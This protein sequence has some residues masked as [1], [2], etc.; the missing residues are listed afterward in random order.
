MRSVLAVVGSK[1]FLGLLC[2]TSLGI[3][4]LASGSQWHKETGAIHLVPVIPTFLG[5]TERKIGFSFPSPFLFLIGG[6]DAEIPGV[7]I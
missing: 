5:S 4:L 2:Q 1:Y 7:G 3:P 6:R